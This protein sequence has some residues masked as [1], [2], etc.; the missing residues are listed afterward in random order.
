MTTRSGSHIAHTLAQL[1][2]AMRAAS[3]PVDALLVPSADEHQAEYPPASAERRAFVSGFSGSA[4]DALITSEHA[5]L[6]TDGRYWTQAEQQLDESLFTLMRSGA[7]AVPTLR[8]YLTRL[9]ERSV[10]AVDARTIP[11]R[12]FLDLQQSLTP[13]GIS[14]ID[15]PRN[16]IDATWADRPAHPAEPVRAHPPALAGASVQDKLAALRDDLARAGA[17]AHAVS[18][19]DAIAWLFNLR[20]AD[21]PFNPL[22]LAHAIITPGRATLFTNPSRLTDDARR[23]LANVADILP[24]DQFE[25]ALLDTPALRW[26][27]DELH[28]SARTATILLNAG[29]RIVERARSPIFAAKARKNPAELVASRLAHL[30]DACALIQTLRWFEREAPSGELTELDIANRVESD[31]RA[32]PDYLSHSFFP[33]AAA[34]PNGAIVHYR[35]TE[36]SNR[37]VRADELFLLDCGAQYLQAATDVTRTLHP[38]T[39]TPEQRRAFTLVLKAHIALASTTFPASANGVQLDAVARMPLWREQHDFNHGTGHG[40]GI[41]V[42][43]NPPSISPRAGALASLAPNMILSIEPGIYIPDH[44]GIRIENLY[45]VQ[46]ANDDASRLRFDPLTLLPIQRNLIDADV[47]TPDER[48]W[49]NDYHARV[50]RELTPHLDTD[51]VAWLTRTTAAI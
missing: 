15:T 16:L 20:G 33:I 37:A 29:R 42:H 49:L 25:P 7:H 28:T 41:S 39:P 26:W 18:S 10:V 9:P 34:G 50:L 32:Q 30:R 5:F 44:L 47:L 51:S 4:G 46:A 21:I 3:P 38:S 45:V 31:R 36:E 6:W 22:F 40:V 43:E 35:P 48:A 14:L 19:L 1:R 13:R 17:E 11:W 27:I 24:Y 23:S 2:S 12:S 8:E